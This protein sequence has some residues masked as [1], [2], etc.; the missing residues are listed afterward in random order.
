MS[1]L[2]KRITRPSSRGRFFPSVRVPQ[3]PCAQCSNR[4]LSTPPSFYTPFVEYPFRTRRRS[5]KQDV[6]NSL[7]ICRT[8]QQ[9]NACIPLFCGTRC[10][11]ATTQRGHFAPQSLEYLAP[12]LSRPDSPGLKGNLYCRTIQVVAKIIEIVGFSQ[13]AATTRTL[14]T[15]TNSMPCIPLTKPRRA[16]SLK[17]LDD[18]STAP[19]SILPKS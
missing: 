9:S 1:L 5:T 17:G 3:S 8:E 15:D 13:G 11:G 10:K 16:A 12:R 7:I 2:G 18:A 4:R 6:F 14:R 19:E